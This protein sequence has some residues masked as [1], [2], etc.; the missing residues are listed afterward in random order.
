M[1]L[2]IPSITQL[3]CPTLVV[4]ASSHGEDACL[5]VPRACRKATDR[6]QSSQRQQRSVTGILSSALGVLRSLHPWPFWPRQILKLGPFDKGQTCCCLHSG[7]LKHVKSDSGCSSWQEIVR[8]MV[9]QVYGM[10]TSGVSRI[11]MRSFLCAQAAKQ[12]D[13]TEQTQQS[14]LTTTPSPL[15][16]MVSILRKWG[17]AWNVKSPTTPGPCCLTWFISAMEHFQ[18]WAPH[19]LPRHAICLWR[20]R[21][22]NCI[23]LKITYAYKNRGM[24]EGGGADRIFWKL[25]FSKCCERY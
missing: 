22:E 21:L 23:K 18:G 4:F 15:H 5:P 3:T 6:L 10:L 14:S 9:W 17:R 1:T 20:W 8:K 12:E 24:V 7:I 19:Y 25:Y 2:L 16:P 11:G 13:E